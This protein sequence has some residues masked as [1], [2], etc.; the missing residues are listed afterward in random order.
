MRSFLTFLMVALFIPFPSMATIPESGVIAFEI[1]RD[2]K[3]I[4]THR[5][6]FSDGP[7]PDTTQADILIEM[8]IA[9]GPIPLFKYRHENREIWRR[10]TPVS[11]IS[12]TND[13]GKDYSVGA[14]WTKNAVSVI[15]NK[16]ENREES[17]PL[18]PTSYWNI[19][20]FES[21]RWLNTQKGGIENITVKKQT[22]RQDGREIILY[23]VDA[24]LPLRVLYDARTKEWIGLEFEAR[25]ADMVYRR[26]TP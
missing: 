26:I 10:N 23:D 16:A 2:G 9:L 22:L 17:S 12:T 7:E 5:I 3:A 15:I 24:S 21:N 1:L 25:G 6:K 20:M 19:A 4:G 11:L 8:R 14:Q 13:N 18:Y